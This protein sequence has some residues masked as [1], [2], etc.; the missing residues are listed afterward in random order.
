LSTGDIDADRAVL[1]AFLLS[2]D[3]ST[4]EIAIPDGYDLCPPSFP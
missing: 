1:A 4:E 2:I 3:P